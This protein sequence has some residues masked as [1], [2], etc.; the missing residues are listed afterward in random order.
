MFFQKE[1]REIET[2]ENR[3]AGKKNLLTT[4]ICF[5]V[6]RPIILDRRAMPERPDIT[7]SVNTMSNW[8][9]C[10]TNRPH[11]NK[12]DAAGVTGNALKN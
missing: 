9:D 3:G 8:H 6:S 10:V 12:P 11:A 2:R 5:R 7:T 1:L 4:G